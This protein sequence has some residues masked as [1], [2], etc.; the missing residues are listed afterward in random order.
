MKILWLKSDFLH[1]TT[2]G[3]QIRTLETLRRLHIR[4]EVHYVAYDNP[5]QPEG[6]KRS[7]EYCARAYPVKL[8]S[9]PKG[10]PKFFL[11]TAAN[12]LSST[13]A[14]ISRYHS[15]TMEQLVAKLVREER[16][17]SLVCDFLTPA[18]NVPKLENCVLFQHNVETMIWRRYAQH[19]PDPLRRAYFG[20]QARRMFEYEGKVC[21]TAGH[22]IAVSKA[23]ADL[24]R[25]MFGATRVSDVATGVDLEYLA[26]PASAPFV[27]DLVFVGSMDWL[28]NMDGME[29]F[30]ENILPRIR[31]RRPGCSLAIVGRNPPQ[32]LKD[33]TAKDPKIT[34]TGTVPDVRP[35]LWGSSVSI[36]PLRIGGGTRLKIYESM[37]AKT[38]VVSTTIGA[39]GLDINPPENIR[40]A[41]TPEAFAEEC[42]ELLE[43]A[44][45]RQRITTAGWEMV[46][47]RFSWEQVTREF[48]RILA[49][50]P[51]P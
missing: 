24:M 49:D 5:A 28:P 27:A 42:V 2:K 32:K 50:G 45:L 26:P 47:S 1:P 51:R 23:D 10:S 25:N 3:G 7:S 31:Q 34:V 38:A 30:L 11:E 29:D 8:E 37:A 40:I 41:D 20:L 12:L 15:K 4:N 16:Y 44:S 9:P 36:V 46:S 21:R 17:D 13:P 33:L 18:P 48:E 39:E 14:V 35:Y 19:A 43:D 22:V 6:L